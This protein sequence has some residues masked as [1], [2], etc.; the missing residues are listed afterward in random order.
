M[1]LALDVGNTNVTL[2]AFQGQRLLRTWRLATDAKKTADEYGVALKALWSPELGRVDAAIYGSV[3]P[4]LNRSI[5]TAVKLYLGASPTG[6]TYKSKLG[7]MLKVDKPA[8][9]GV[10][11]ILNALAVYRLYGAPAVV[12]DFGTA[13]TFDCVSP[14]GWYLGGAI[15]PG[16]R[17]AARALKEHTAQLPEVA[18]SKPERVVGKNTV[19][20]IQ[21]GVYYGYLGMID[22]VLRETVREMNPKNPRAVKVY[23]TGG[24]AG[25]FIEDLGGI[26]QVADLTLQGLRLAYEALEL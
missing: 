17:L 21:A 2:G 9:V 4:E 22:R 12:I 16:P 10:D 11:R 25:L 3:V 14:R 15:L 8:E 6:I 13:T 26:Q 24:L 20:C 5:E 18:V 23:S 1:L 7:I 19:E